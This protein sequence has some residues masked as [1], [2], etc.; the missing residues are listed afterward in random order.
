MCLSPEGDLIAGVVVVAIGVDACRH[1][2]G[3][4]EYVFV[5]GLPLLLGVHQLM[6]TFVWWGLQGHV[7]A[8]VGEVAMWL[9]LLIA[10][11]ALPVLVPALVLRLEPTAARRRRIIPFVGLGVLIGGWLLVAMLRAHPVAE[12]GHLHI[13]YDVGLSHGTVVAAVYFTATC[14]A[15]LASGLRHVR[16]F[17]LA[18][19]V[20]VVVLARLTADGF[21]SLWCFYAALASAAIALYMRFGER[22]PDGTAVGLAD[23][24]PAPP[25]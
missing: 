4:S 21:A 23:P 24:A 16:W 6:E 8:R 25:S 7:P 11:V 3:R 14:G 19:L 22:T 9:Y 18:N 1:L 5:A 20:A 2:R 15:M 10:F 17:G 12:L 13:A